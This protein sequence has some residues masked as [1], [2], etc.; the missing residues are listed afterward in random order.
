MERVQGL[1]PCA[2]PILEYETDIVV[3]SKEYYFSLTEQNLS[4]PKKSYLA[5]SYL[6]CGIWAQKAKINRCLFVTYILYKNVTTR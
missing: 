6:K 1:E 3:V 5:V 4:I 2:Y